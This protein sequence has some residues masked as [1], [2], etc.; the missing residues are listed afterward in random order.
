M[1]DF[2]Q[3]LLQISIWL[4]LGKGKGKGKEKVNA[5]S[6]CISVPVFLFLSLFLFRVP[7]LSYRNLQYV[8]LVGPTYKITPAEPEPESVFGVGHRSHGGVPELECFD[9]R[10]E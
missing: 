6:Y 7:T 10:N 3:V 1:S 5:V 2:A 9:H 8:P 4:A